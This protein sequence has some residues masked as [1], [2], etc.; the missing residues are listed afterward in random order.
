MN[1]VQSR[2]LEQPDDN[3]NNFDCSLPFSFFFYLYRF[4]ILNLGNIFE[5][6]IDANH[7]SSKG[8]MTLSSMNSNLCKI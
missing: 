2:L 7:N 8:I 5:T 3:V 6:C 1:G 4:G